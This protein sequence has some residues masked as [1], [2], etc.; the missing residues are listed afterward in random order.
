MLAG[1]MQ[2]TELLDMGATARCVKRSWKHYQATGDGVELNAEGWAELTVL[3]SLFRLDSAEQAMA[4]LFSYRLAKANRQL[5]QVQRT[6]DQ[7]VFDGLGLNDW[8]PTEVH[9]LF[10]G[11]AASAR[12]FLNEMR[13]SIN[14]PQWIE[15]AAAV[16][17]FAHFI[18][19]DVVP[20]ARGY[21]FRGMNADLYFGDLAVALVRR[22][23]S[24]PFRVKEQDVL[25]DVD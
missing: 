22:V 13:G 25:G 10:D 1:A 15:R 5:G 16:R 9:S 3:Q 18:E 20:M 7:R 8:L 6:D 24:G 11:V 12:N 17:R 19:T 23:K 4:V 2:A 21:R 14:Q